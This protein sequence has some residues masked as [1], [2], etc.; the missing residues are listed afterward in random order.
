VSETMSHSLKLAGFTLIIYGRQFPD[1]ID[2]WDGNWLF[3]TCSCRAPGSF[4]EVKGS[5]VRVDELQ[6]LMK[7][8]ESMYSGS[9]EKC[10]MNCMEPE[11]SFRFDTAKTGEIS[12][13]VHLTPDNL[14]QSH[15]IK[16]K[17]DRS[18]LPAAIEQCKSIL[19][20]YPIRDEQASHAS[21]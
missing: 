3:V 6:H 5:I 1:A 16:F 15:S 9:Q 20:D 11:L 4:V 7:C 21:D 13:E 8:L 18:Y 19:E 12:F 14:N 10:E 17:I 2:Y